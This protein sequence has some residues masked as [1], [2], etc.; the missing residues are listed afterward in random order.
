MDNIGAKVG[1]TIECCGIAA[2]ESLTKGSSTIYLIKI[3]YS[4]NE[5]IVYFRN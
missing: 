4:V 3:Q 1:K 2:K 5:L